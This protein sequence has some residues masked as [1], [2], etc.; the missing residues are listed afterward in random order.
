MM[1]STFKN[2][3]KWIFAVLFFCMAVQAAPG[4]LDASFNG[5]GRLRV[6]IGA[7]GEGA[8]YEQGIVRQSDGKIVVASSCQDVL[9]NAGFCT[10]RYNTNGS[11][12]TSFGTNGK[13][14]TP[15]GS[16]S[17]GTSAAIQ[18][19]GKILVGGYAV[20][21]GGYFGFGIVRYNSNGA[22]DTTFDG[23]GIVIV[24]LGYNAC[25]NALTVQSDGKIVAAGAA[26]S[27]VVV[28]LNSN[29]SPD[30][31]FDGDGIALTAASM[32]GTNLAVAMQGTKIVTAGYADNNAVLIRYN[33]NGSLDTTFGSGGIVVTTNGAGTIAARSLTFAGAYAGEDKIIVTGAVRATAKATQYIAI[34]SYNQSNGTP[35]LTFGTS[36]GRVTTGLSGTGYSIKTQFSYG[37]ADKIVVA[38]AGSGASGWREPDAKT[39]LTIPA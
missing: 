4:D 19:D 11:I 12:D 23:D 37:V 34:W 22:L 1:I 5:T 38:G 32:G 29:G 26:S 10:V 14:L 30:T 28:R 21:P 20:L 8:Q 25:L 17:L 9:T 3:F 33:A 31:T 6:P 16:S 27:F 15:V 36:G 35:D 39:E 2:S 13:V 18:A 7:S 24:D